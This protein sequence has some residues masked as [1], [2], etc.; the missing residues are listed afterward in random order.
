MKKILSLILAVMML[1]SVTAFAAGMEGSDG[2]K[3]MKG[4]YITYNGTDKGGYG[5]GGVSFLTD[6]VRNTFGA[7]H[8]GEIK[9]EFGSEVSFSGIRVW[10]SDNCARPA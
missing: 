4:A 7:K 5:A 10:M 2:T 6:G 1:F 8:G 3:S 9:I